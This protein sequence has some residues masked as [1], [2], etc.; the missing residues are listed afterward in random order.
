MSL[1]SRAR[2]LT[3]DDGAPDALTVTQLYE[4]VERAVRGAFPEDVWVTGE[5]RS[6]KVLTKG[7]CFLE[8]VD[9]AQADDPGAPTLSAKCWAGTW[10]SVRVSLDRLGI[11][12]EAGMVVRVRGEVGLY[13]ARGSVDF[14]VRELD[15]EA[16]LGRV[17]A[18][19][20]RLVRALVD[21]DLYD[22]QRR[23]R[24]PMLPLRVGLV[25]SP[26]TEGF[27]DFLGGL[28]G[29]ELAF[30]VTVAPTAV[31]GKD[32]P[33][34]VAGAI[35]QLQT[36]P[37]DVI[38]VVRGGGSKADLAAFDQ[39]VVARAV[40]TSD[41]P[42]WTGIGHTGDQSVADE[43][44]HRAFITPTE[45]GQELAR[46]ALD[47]WRGIEDAGAVLTRVSRDRVRQADK[48]L[49][50]HQR[51]MATGAR[52]QLDRHADSLGH[53]ARNLRTVV[54]GQVD[55][56]SRRLVVAAEAGVRA[57]RRATL[58]E[59]AGLELRAGRLVGLPARLLEVEELRAAQ[60]RRLLGA[61]DYQRQL[62]RGYSVTRDAS[63]AVLRSVVGLVP[64]TVLATQLADGTVDSTV[65]G[66]S[67]I[68]TNDTTEGST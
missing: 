38:V 50:A 15:T 42:V 65:T 10:R 29:S 2:R 9:P 49:A 68:D 1:E 25:A 18:E 61:Y 48:A 17:A 44:A 53:R 24:V 11:A 63:G 37:L 8:L 16:L 22:R 26:G 62:E 5:V 58:D 35:A 30:D 23:L 52:I 27:N 19:R 46:V 28:E 40:A 66:A 7:H 47:Y 4:R 54:R 57:A 33:A 36:Q 3:A 6:M 34:M 20:A 12:L 60:R 55:T 51:A 14:V 64:G 31:Q 39:E 21:E 45:C 32:A 13:K 41:I 43:V 56:H 59:E 67:T